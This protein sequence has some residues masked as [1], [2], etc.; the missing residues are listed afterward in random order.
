MLTRVEG[1]K[2]GDRPALHSCEVKGRGIWRKISAKNRRGGRLGG[3]SILFG[4]QLYFLLFQKYSR[5]MLDSGGD[6]S[7]AGEGR[8]K[9]FKGEK[10]IIIY[11]RQTFVKMNF[12]I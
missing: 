5:S 8:L 3:N 12:Y 1:N 10:K 6:M 7:L 9:H 4:C 11:S 2:R